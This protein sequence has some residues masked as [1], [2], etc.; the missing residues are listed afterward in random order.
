MNP[1]N[2]NVTL[3]SAKKHVV[4]IDTAAKY[5]Y[6]EHPDGSEGGGLWFSPY[7]GGTLELTDYDGTYELH[8]SIVGALRDAGYHLD[9]TFD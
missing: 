1:Y 4:Q 2:F 6:W 5:G 3:V 7:L 9:E 8:A